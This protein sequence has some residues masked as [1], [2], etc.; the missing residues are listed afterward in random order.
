M[1]AFFI[2]YFPFESFCQRGDDFFLLGDLLE[3]NLFNTR[4]FI[5]RQ[6]PFLSEKKKVV[7]HEREKRGTICFPQHLPVIENGGYEFRSL[8]TVAQ[9]EGGPGGPRRLGLHPKT[10]GGFAVRM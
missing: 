7:Q 3:T 8:L 1:Y 5:T 10:R 2:F 9:P 4:K 6:I